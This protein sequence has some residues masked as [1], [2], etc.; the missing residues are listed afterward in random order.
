MG[1]NDLIISEPKTGIKRSKRTYSTEE[2]F[3]YRIG[4]NRLLDHVSIIVDY[5]GIDGF[6]HDCLFKIGGEGK[7][8][9]AKMIDD[10]KMPE[11][12]EA[13]INKI[14]IQRRFKLCLATPAIFKQGWLPDG[15]DEETLIWRRDGL[16]LKLIAACVGKY[17]SIGGWDIK[18]NEPKPMQRAVPGGSVYYFDIIKGSSTSIIEGLQ[19]KNI[20]DEN[21]EQGFGLSFVGIV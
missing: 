4:M 15:I 6:E 21:P 11:L 14:N 17:L 1:I 3:L 20:S 16:T 7:A 13:S 5:A 10:L 18:N 9:H 2:G 12:S 19:Y 8:A